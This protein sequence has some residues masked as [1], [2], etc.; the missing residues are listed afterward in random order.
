MS[1]A[2]MQKVGQSLIKVIETY[3]PSQALKF[4]VICDKVFDIFYEEFIKFVP[5]YV[6]KREQ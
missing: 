4:Q 5:S 6:L 3:L 2:D 1:T